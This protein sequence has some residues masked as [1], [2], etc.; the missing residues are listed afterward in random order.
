MSTNGVEPSSA[1]PFDGPLDITSI[2]LSN[3]GNTEAISH[4]IMSTDEFEIW[5]TRV[6]V[7]DNFNQPIFTS[8]HNLRVAIN[9]GNSTVVVFFSNTPPRAFPES[10]DK[11]FM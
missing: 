7:T 4:I 11:A 8:I 5:D 1:Y 9:T 10:I 2:S 3:D 6:Q